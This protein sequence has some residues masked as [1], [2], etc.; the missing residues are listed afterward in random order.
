MYPGSV[1]S[2]RYNPRKQSILV[3][4]QG[5]QCEKNREENFFAILERKNLEEDQMTRL[6]LFKFLSVTSYVM[7]DKSLSPWFCFFICQL[8]IMMV[9][10]S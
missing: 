8:E 3:E 5:V 2:K 1:P 9:P 7:L 6:G 4:G 10:K